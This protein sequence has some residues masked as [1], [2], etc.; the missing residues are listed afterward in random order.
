MWFERNR[1][2]RAIRT[3]QRFREAR[4]LGA[5]G[6]N[7]QLPQD[8]HRFTRCCWNIVSVALAT[9]GVPFAR[10]SNEVGSSGL[11]SDDDPCIRS[12]T[13]LARKSAAQQMITCSLARNRLTP[14]P[15]S[16]TPPHRR[17]LSYGPSK[18]HNRN[19]PCDFQHPTSPDL[20]HHTPKAGAK[21]TTRNS[22]PQQSSEGWSFLGLTSYGIISI[23]TLLY[24]MHRL[25]AASTFLSTHAR[26]QHRHALCFLCDLLFNPVLSNHDS[27]NKLDRTP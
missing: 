9:R 19:R 22:P 15:N 7:L 25:L 14:H 21:P 12:F 10:N 27:T 2:V 13:A 1:T 17:T 16:A 6:V 3:Q 23:L 24:I 5:S 8:P 11:R 18:D 20:L 4:E 26:S